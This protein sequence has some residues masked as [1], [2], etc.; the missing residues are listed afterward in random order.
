MRQ[1]RVAVVQHPDMPRPRKI[2]EDRRETMHRRP[3]ASVARARGGGRARL[4]CGDGTAQ[5]SLRAR[6]RIRRRQCLIARYVG[7]LAAHR[8]RLGAPG[9]RL[10]SMTSREYV[11]AIRDRIEHRRRAATPRRARRCPRRYAPKARQVPARRA[12]RARANAPA[13][14]IANQQERRS[15]MFAFDRERRRSS[16]PSRRRVQGFAASRRCVRS[17]ATD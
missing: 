8:D 10:Q 17:M 16:A 11:C 6:G 9:G 2:V 13:G 5:R 14:V 1:P 15:A 3:A 12:C 7:A 4:R